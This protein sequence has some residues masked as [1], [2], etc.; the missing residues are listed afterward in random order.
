ML[1]KKHVAT[2]YLIVDF[3]GKAASAIALG[4]PNLVRPSI[5]L[6]QLYALAQAQTWQV[7][8]QAASGRVVQV[9]RGWVVDID[10][11]QGAVLLYVYSRT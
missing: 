4:G 8:E 5:H 2:L 11:P 10:G 7:L 9:L 3:E 1:S 6:G